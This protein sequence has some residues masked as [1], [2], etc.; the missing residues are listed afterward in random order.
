MEKIDTSSIKN[1]MVASKNRPIKAKPLIT[2]LVDRSVTNKFLVDTLE[3]RESLGDGSV[4]CVGEAGDI[5][6][7]T[8]KKLLQKYYVKEIDRDGWMLCEPLPDNAA[9]VYEPKEDECGVDGLFYVIG[10]W[11]EAIGEE[12]NIQRG[13][14]GDFICRNQTDHS[15]VWVI[16]RSL[17]LNTYNIKS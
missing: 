16:R 13:K 17:F 6:Q 5:W 11:G 8:Q 14:L 12:K 15:D 1:W 9:D 4:I 7:Q 2:L 10:H 3:G